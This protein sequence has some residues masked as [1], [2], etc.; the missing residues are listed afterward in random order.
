LEIIACVL[1]A[2]TIL[3][4]IIFAVITLLVLFIAEGLG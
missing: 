3:A 2:L 4:A 1:R